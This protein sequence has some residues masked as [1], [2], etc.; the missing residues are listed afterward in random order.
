MA[1]TNFTAGEGGPEQLPRGSATELNQNTDVQAPEGLDVAPAP[2]A[3]PEAAP[4]ETVEEAPDLEMAQED[5]SED[6]QPAEAADFEPLYEP[7][8]E[9]EEFLI[10][11]SGRPDE[12]QWVGA[13]DRR[14]LPAAVRRHIGPLQEAAAMPGASPELI[15]LV[16]YLLRMS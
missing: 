5:G 4:A 7:Q 14:V 12:A 8:S 3:A 15:A 6:L 1:E 9:D 10:G 16:Q 13:N 2:E 11:P